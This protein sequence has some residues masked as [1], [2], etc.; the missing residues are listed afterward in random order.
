M[1][2]I[3]SFLWSCKFTTNVK[4]VA[5]RKKDCKS[6]VR[7]II[8]ACQSVRVKNTDYCSRSGYKL[9]QTQLHYLSV[10]ICLSSTRTLCPLKKTPQL[11]ATPLDA[12]SETQAYTVNTLILS[13]TLCAVLT[14]HRE[15][16]SLISR[17]KLICLTNAFAPL[18]WTH[19]VSCDCSSDLEI[20]L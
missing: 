7:R 9:M 20:F 12:L 15:D 3:V 4:K 2:G 13:A 1:T 14:N 19:A 10:C 16:V 8:Q 17:L 11:S 18:C 6:A 5:S